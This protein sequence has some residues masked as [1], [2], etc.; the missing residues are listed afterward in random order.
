MTVPTLTLD[1]LLDYFSYPTFLKIDVEGAE[2]LVLKG[3]KRLLS[4]IRPTIYIEV[5]SEH[6]KAVTKI[7]I[8]S[9]YALF[10]GSLPIREQKPA[11]SCAF[12]TIAVPHESL[13][14]QK[15]ALSGARTS[16]R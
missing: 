16:L 13:L 8:E 4:E 7:L 5:G 3:A 11:T 2:A 1:T 9:D 14:A 12:N 10:D 15:V 6:D